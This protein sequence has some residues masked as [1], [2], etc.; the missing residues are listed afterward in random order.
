[1]NETPQKK[2]DFLTLVLVFKKECPGEQC[3]W[4]APSSHATAFVINK[5][6]IFTLDITSLSYEPITFSNGKFK[7][8][9]FCFQK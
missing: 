7:E 4:F 2:K 3:L 1:M 9:K 5:R 8:I 6:N